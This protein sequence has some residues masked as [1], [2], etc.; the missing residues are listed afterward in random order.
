MEEDPAH[1]RGPVLHGG[2]A[3]EPAGHHGTQEEVQGES[4]RH[5]RENNH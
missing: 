1:R 2:H 4:V 3:C 5:R